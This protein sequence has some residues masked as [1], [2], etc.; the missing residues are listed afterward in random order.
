MLILE[1]EQSLAPE[2]L[3][4]L[5]NDPALHPNLA[6]NCGHGPALSEEQ[7]DG[8]PDHLAVRGA[9][10]ARAMLQFAAL[11]VAQHNLDGGPGRHAADLISF[12]ARGPSFW[13]PTCGG[14]Y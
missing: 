13:S 3:G 6:P 5:A 1:A 9:V 12:G 11:R 7:D 2:A 10:S 14:L 8:R 4:P